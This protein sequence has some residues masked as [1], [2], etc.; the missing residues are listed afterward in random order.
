MNEISSLA[1]K[2]DLVS[3]KHEKEIE[4]KDARIAELEQKLQSMKTGS[5]R[6]DSSR[7]AFKS[8][9]ADVENR[10]VE[11][12]TSSMNPISLLSTII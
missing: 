6:Q 5:V 2:L 4:E 12:N 10:S 8:R 9:F 11:S 1:R 3:T 7:E